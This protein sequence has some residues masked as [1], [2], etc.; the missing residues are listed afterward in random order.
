MR[1]Y[2]KPEIRKNIVTLQSVTSSPNTTGA[3]VNPK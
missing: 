3:T 1:K 2:K